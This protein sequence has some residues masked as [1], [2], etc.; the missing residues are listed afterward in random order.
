MS[1]PMQE[2]AK[3][4]FGES[5]ETDPVAWGKQK[6]IHLW[7]KQREIAESVVHNRYTAVRSSHDGGK[8]FGCAFLA[9]WWLDV[10]EVGDAFVVSTA[11]SGPQVSAILW[12]EIE[13]LHRKLKLRGK[14]SVGG[15]PEWKVDKELIGYGR[16]PSDYDENGFQGIHALYPLIIVDE[17]CGIPRQLWNAVDALATNDN[18]RVVAIGNPDDATSH[19][20]TICEPGSGWNVIH[21]DGLSTPNFSEQAVKAIS[22]EDGCGDLY[23]FFLDNG[24]PFSTEDIPEVLRQ[25]L[26]S[27]RWVAERMHRWG[28]RRQ[29]DDEQVGGLP[30]WK[31][32]PLWDAKVRGEFSDQTTEGVI[33]LAWVRAAQERWLEQQGTDPLGRRMFVCDVAR[34]GQDETAI[35]TRQGHVV[36]DIMSIG[37]QDT[38]TTANQLNAMLDHPRSFSVVDV[39]GIGAGVVDRLNELHREV[40]PFNGSLATTAVDR[41]GTFTFPNVRSA[42]WWKLREALDPTFTP[43]LCLPPNDELC[44]D[45]IA[46]RWRLLSGGKIQVEPKEDTIKRLGRS[47]DMGDT[48]VMSEWHAS[49][50]VTTEVNPEQQGYA[51]AYGGESEYSVSYE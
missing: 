33:P 32:S 35:A 37:Q 50:G 34:F 24:L 13:K 42:A 16:K 21:L 46:P 6:G 41:S 49:G 22:H 1:D 20:K 25:S 48:I 19:F 27:V 45:L 11:P 12:R 10:H 39:I 4:F 47:P 7:S 30:R 51:R 14:I 43:T 2:A 17:A 5:Y 29:T 18:A 9:C 38:M 15:Q 26:L 28:V 36:L 8:S 40:I 3:R 44:A 23:Q 31:T